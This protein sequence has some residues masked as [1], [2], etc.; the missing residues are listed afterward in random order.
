MTKNFNG[1]ES[2]MKAT[3]MSERSVTRISEELELEPRFITGTQRT[4]RFW[5]AE[6][7]EKIKARGRKSA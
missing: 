7:I 4:R 6:D 1:V 3:N 2:V 5:T